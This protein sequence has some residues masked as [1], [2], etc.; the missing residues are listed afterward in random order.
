MKTKQGQLIDPMDFFQ[1]NTCINNGM[2]IDDG[3]VAAGEFMGE[4]ECC[5]VGTLWYK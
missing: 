5:H 4:Q 2:S 3:H 1:S